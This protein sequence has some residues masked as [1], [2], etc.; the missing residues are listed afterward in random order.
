MIELT[1]KIIDKAFE[2][3][4]HQADIVSALYRI[5]FPKWDSIGQIDG[6][7]QVN[8]ETDKYIFDL[9]IAYDKEN[10]PDVVSGGLWLNKGFG[11]SDDIE[12]WIVDT[13][14][15]KLTYNE[16]QI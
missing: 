12:E 15:C 8:T 3:A 5:A 13:S 14:N 16:D 7:P 9:F 2:N 1:K 10:H 11:S 6:H 4:E